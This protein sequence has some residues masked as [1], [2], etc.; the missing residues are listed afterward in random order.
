MIYIISNGRHY[1]IGYSEHPA[2]RLKQL[3]TGSSDKLILVGVANGTRKDEERI[4]KAFYPQRIRGEWFRLT[5]KDIRKIIDQK[6]HQ[7]YKV[8]LC[9]IL[10]LI[11]AWQLWSICT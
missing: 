1:K 4:Q 5:K 10:H 7:P 11:I 2:N 6:A 9:W 3:Q 8:A